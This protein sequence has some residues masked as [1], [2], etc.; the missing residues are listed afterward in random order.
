VTKFDAPSIDIRMLIPL[1]VMALCFKLYYAA[2]LLLRARATVLERERNSQWVRE[3]V[4][5][6]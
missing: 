1:L 6:K 2:L 4:S 3:L 5:A